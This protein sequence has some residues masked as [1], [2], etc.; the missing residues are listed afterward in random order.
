MLLNEVQKQQRTIGTLRAQVAAA[1]E[2][3]RARDEQVRTLTEQMAALTR[4]VAE[5]G[6][7]ECFMFYIL[8]RHRL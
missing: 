7:E 5:A 6:A 3:T 8:Q 2:Q 4:A 1:D